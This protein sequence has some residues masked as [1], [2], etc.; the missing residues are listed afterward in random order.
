[1]TGMVEGTLYYY[2]DTY[3]DIFVYVFVYFS[4]SLFKPHG[5]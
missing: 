1:M 5:I 2:V 3:T 4:I